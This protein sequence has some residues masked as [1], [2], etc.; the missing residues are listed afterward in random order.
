MIFHSFIALCSS[1]EHFFVL[2]LRMHHSRVFFSWHFF[3]FFSSSPSGCLRTK[4]W[5][6]KVLGFQF[7]MADRTTLLGVYG[8]QKGQID[9]GL[10]EWVAR[11]RDVMSLPFGHSHD[12]PVF[13]FWQ[14]WFC[15]FFFPADAEEQE[16]CD[17]IR[18]KISFAR[19]LGYC[20]QRR[21]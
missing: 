15:F 14:P 7:S 18:A 8:V 17:E 11:E 9:R 20:N 21:G 5:H 13:D 19:L 16:I 2:Y 10:S 3:F 6:Q 1:T 12:V 4:C